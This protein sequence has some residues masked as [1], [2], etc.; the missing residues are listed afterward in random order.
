MCLVTPDLDNN[1]KNVFTQFHYCLSRPVQME[2]AGERL[3]FGGAFQD[4]PY[5]SESSFIPA[6]P[7]TCVDESVWQS[8]TR[9]GWFFPC[10]DV[11][12][13]SL[14]FPTHRTTTAPLRVLGTAPMH[15][16]GSACSLAT[17][18]LF[19]FHFSLPHL[20]TAFTVH[21]KKCSPKDSWG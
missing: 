4:L 16:R 8:S 20:L 13:A 10:F 19:L 6:A 15:H 21:K 12:K 7:P 2:G 1:C 11:S 5:R 3:I 17:A 9:P 14:S 18:S